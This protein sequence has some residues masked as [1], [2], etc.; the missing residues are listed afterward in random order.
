MFV[1]ADVSGA[2]NYGISKNLIGRI[3]KA[4]FCLHKVSV[5]LK[6]ALHIKLSYTNFTLEVY[7]KAAPGSKA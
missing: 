6:F 5:W 2:L 1:I 4:S 3:T 7:A